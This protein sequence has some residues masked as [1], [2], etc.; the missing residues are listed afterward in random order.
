[1]T[2]SVYALGEGTSLSH[3]IKSMVIGLKASNGDMNA[4]QFDKRSMPP[5]TA[6]PQGAFE[7]IAM[8]CL[9]TYQ[10]WQEEHRKASASGRRVIGSRVAARQPVTS[11]S[12]VISDEALAIQQKYSASWFNAYTRVALL[13]SHLAMATEAD[14]PAISV[15]LEKARVD[16]RAIEAARDS[17]VRA[18]NERS[19][20][21]DNIRPL[22]KHIL[23]LSNDGSGEVAAQDNADM[24]DV[25]KTHLRVTPIGVKVMPSPVAVLP[26][27][28]GMPEYQGRLSEMKTS[29]DHAIQ[30]LEH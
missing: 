23:I 29:I 5:P 19:R 22:G 26:T 9:N 6:E 16:L 21:K 10:Q 20:K 15:R 7:H 27:V 12:A 18:G 17:E 4:L 13:E 14:K 24:V 11:T 8:D 3:A 30:V 25:A 2:K 1:M 28:A